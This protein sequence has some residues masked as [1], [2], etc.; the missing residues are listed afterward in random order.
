MSKYF[1]FCF[2]PTAGTNDI[3]RM[4]S[5]IIYLLTK[6]DRP[7]ACTKVGKIIAHSPDSSMKL[8]K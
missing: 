6:T 7:L 2:W 8:I 4:L 5:Q 1:N 3:V